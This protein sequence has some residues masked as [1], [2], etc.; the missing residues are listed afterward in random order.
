MRK[1]EGRTSLV[2]LALGAAVLSAGCA[3]TLEAPASL[4]T[5]TAQASVV[6]MTG[7]ASGSLVMD[8]GCVRLASA[9]GASRLVV[10]PHGTR[11]TGDVPARITLG[12]GKSMAIGQQVRLGGGERDDLPPSMLA[13]APAAACVG[14]YFIA[15]DLIN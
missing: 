11:L 10:W 2:A 4:P 12:N 8:R 1:R 5:L 14:P 13:T 15:A 3:S 7:M 6:Q 9:S